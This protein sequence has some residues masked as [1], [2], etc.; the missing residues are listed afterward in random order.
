MDGGTLARKRSIPAV[1]TANPENAFGQVCASRKNAPTGLNCLRWTCGISPS[2]FGEYRIRLPYRHILCLAPARLACCRAHPVRFPA[3]SMAPAPR[4]SSA[5]QPFE[6]E[7]SLRLSSGTDC[8]ARWRARRHPKLSFG[9]R[10]E[11]IIVRAGAR[12]VIRY[13][14]FIKKARRSAGHLRME[15]TGFEPVTY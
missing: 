8:R 9:C 3:P 5:L 4:I 12:G 1:F 11:R 6:S 2:S 7:A 13:S 14:P 10:V 15:N